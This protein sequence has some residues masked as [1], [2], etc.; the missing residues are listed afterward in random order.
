MLQLTLSS[1][2]LLDIRAENVENRKTVMHKRLCFYERVST[3]VYVLSK[4][5]AYVKRR[6]ARIQQRY[7]VTMFWEYSEDLNLWL[8]RCAALSQ[9]RGGC[10][11]ANKGQACGEVFNCRFQIHGCNPFSGPASGRFFQI[12]ACI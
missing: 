5:R 6:K 1:F 7:R 12:V 4:Y 8:R 3:I 9:C 11:E 2:T 10:Q